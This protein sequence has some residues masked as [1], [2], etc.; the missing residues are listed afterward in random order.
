M[1]RMGFDIKYIFSLMHNK[2]ND[3]TY[4]AIFHQELYLKLNIMQQFLLLKWL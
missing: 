1:L 4:I 2:I 3:F